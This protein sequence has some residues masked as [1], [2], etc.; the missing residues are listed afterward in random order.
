M[1]LAAVLFV[2]VPNALLVDISGTA[3]GCSCIATSRDGRWLAAAC[4][5][6]TG[7]FK[8]MMVFRVSH[9]S[10]HYLACLGVLQ[11]AM[12]LASCCL[13]GFESYMRLG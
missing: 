9:F 13:I 4:G 2:Q 1:S 8:V 3:G 12:W 7:R 10:L 11:G 6:T 5:D